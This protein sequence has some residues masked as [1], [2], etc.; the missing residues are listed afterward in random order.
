M[1]NSLVSSP[2][3]LDKSLHPPKPKLSKKFWLIFILSDLIIALFVFYT[4]VNK[5]SENSSN[6]LSRIKSKIEG[7]EI[8][9]PTPFPF[10]EMTIPYLRTRTYNSKLGEMAE[11]SQSLDSSYSAYLTNYTSDGLKINAFLTKPTGT[12]P[13]GGWPA[14]VF[15]HGYIPPTQYETNGQAYSAYVDYLGSRGFVVFKIDLRGHGESEGE[16]GGGYFGSDYVVDA[17]NAY[18][19]LQNSDFVNPKKIGLWGHSMAGNIVMR[20]IAVKPDIPAVDIWAGA[21]YTYTDREKYGINDQSYRP[22]GLSTNLQNR[23]RELIAKYGNPSEKSE[24]WKQVIPT[25]YL[26]D[27]KGAIQIN[28]ARDDAVVNIGYSRDLIALLNKSSVPHELYEYES[29]GHNIT[30]SSFNQAMERTVEFY[31]KYLTVTN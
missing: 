18:S 2:N 26:G 5:S 4:F 7:K 11:Q 23:R 17:L 27:I 16:P 29:G 30:G 25:N 13:D 22:P 10:Q 12:I 9:S 31:K 15:I 14:I 6:P 28:H 19:A 8:L 1:E 21:V 3:T 20:S 24:F